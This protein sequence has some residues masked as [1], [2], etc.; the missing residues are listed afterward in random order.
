MESEN[1]T[2]TSQPEQLEEISEVVNTP[3]GEN[4]EVPTSI[5]H[6]HSRIESHVSIKEQYGLEVEQT[7][8]GLSIA[9]FHCLP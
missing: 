1:T 5:C 7:R 4:I 6:T 2:E 8:Q 9:A 3:I